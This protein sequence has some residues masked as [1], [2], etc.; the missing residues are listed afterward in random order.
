MDKE[1]IE[2]RIEDVFEQLA[3]EYDDEDITIADVK[4]NMCLDY[5]AN[6]D[7]G[8]G[9]FIADGFPLEHIEKID[10]L[11]IFDDDLEASQYAELI[12]VK[13]AHDIVF[14]ENSPYYYYNG[15]ILD[16][17]QNR[18]LYEQMKAEGDI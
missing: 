18:R 9:F 11:D 5:G 4:E 13:I 17:K 15:T 12:G 6:A 16:T 7:R 1:A 10:E 3:K 2:K 14:D 8:F